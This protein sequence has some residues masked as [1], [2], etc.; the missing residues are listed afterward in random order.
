MIYLLAWG[1]LCFWQ[2]KYNQF[3]ITCQLCEILTQ[4]CSGFLSCRDKPAASCHLLRKFLRRQ[5][6]RLRPVQRLVMMNGPISVMS[7]QSGMRVQRPYFRY[8]NYMRKVKK[9]QASSELRSPAHKT[10]TWRWGQVIKNTTKDIRIYNIDSLRRFSLQAIFYT[11]EIFCLS[12]DATSCGQWK[13]KQFG[14]NC[15]N[16]WMQYPP[17]FLLAFWDVIQQL[18]DDQWAFYN[19][20][21]PDCQKMS[22]NCLRFVWN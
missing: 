21:C 6:Q 18:H 2:L 9:E 20:S 13:K 19:C 22:F 1:R 10:K 17:C 7:L 3:F 5:S 11:S 15:L 4:V 12:S 8:N 14:G 16:E